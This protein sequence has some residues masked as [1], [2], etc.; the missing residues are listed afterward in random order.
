VGVYDSIRGVGGEDA[1]GCT[2]TRMR[3]LQCALRAR[4]NRHEDQV[5]EHS[6]R[7]SFIEQV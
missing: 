3:A 6:G 5:V 1:Q 2:E 4:A 7:T